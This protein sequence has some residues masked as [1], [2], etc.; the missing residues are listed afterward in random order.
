MKKLVIVGTGGH[1]KVVVDTL[2]GSSDVVILGFVDPNK[3]KGSLFLGYPILGTDQYLLNAKIDDI[4]LI[5]GIGTAKSCAIRQQ[6]FLQF[7][8]MGYDFHTTIHPTAILG[9]G[10]RIGGGSQVM[11]GTIVQPAVTIGENVII[12]TGAIIEHDTH[13]GDHVHIA[14]GSV[15]G[16]GVTIED[17][18]FVGLGARLLP[19]VRI[20]QGATIGAGALVLSDVEAGATVIGIHKGGK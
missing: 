1:A 6:T 2:Q 7:K 13:I 12:N 14:P 15:L 8:V 4:T 3:E 9:R 17:S 18:V 19:Q 20:G 5:I 10:V 11:A 16:G